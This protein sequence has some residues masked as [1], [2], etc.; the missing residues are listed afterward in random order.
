MVIYRKDGSVYTLYGQKK[1]PAKKEFPTLEPIKPK[2]EQMVLP[3]EFIQET[4]V[5]EVQTKFVCHPS[6]MKSIGNEIEGERVVI[7]KLDPIEVFGTYIE[8][9][10]ETSKIKFHLNFEQYSELY[11]DDETKQKWVVSSALYSPSDAK[12]VHSCYLE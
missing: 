12:Y 7:V 10:K 1:V 9:K 4:P 2:V 5:D 8:V 11:D 6:K 3:Q